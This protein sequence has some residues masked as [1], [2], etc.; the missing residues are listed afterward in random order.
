MKLIHQYHKP[1]PEWIPDS[2]AKLIRDSTC[3]TFGASNTFSKL[4]ICFGDMQLI[5][6]FDGCKM[7]YIICIT[8]QNPTAFLHAPWILP[9]PRRKAWRPAFSWTTE[10][11]TIGTLVAH[12]RTWNRNFSW[13][14][15]KKRLEQNKSDL[16]NS[17]FTPLNGIPPPL[18]GAK[19]SAKLNWLAAQRAAQSQCITDWA[20]AGPCGTSLAALMAGKWLRW[21]HRAPFDPTKMP[22]GELQKILIEKLY[23]LEIEAFAS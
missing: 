8:F 23:A 10:Q 19:E 4:R 11:H 3:S 12:L 5:I 14:R 22:S 1:N 13:L 18:S 20:T 17:S 7:D 15:D 16:I 9:V 6:Y 21:P 2:Y